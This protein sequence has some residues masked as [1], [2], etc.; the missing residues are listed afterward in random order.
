M[1]ELRQQESPMNTKLTTMSTIVTLI[2]ASKASAQQAEAP[3]HPLETPASAFE[4]VGGAYYTQGFGSLQSGVDMQHV[5]TPGLSTE[6]GVGYRINPRWA[7][8]LVG[9]YQE[10]DAQRANQARG[11]TFGVAATF[12]ATPYSRLDPWVQLGTGYR[13]L[14]E[15]SIAP[16][17]DLVTHGFELAKLTVGLDYR[18]TR[19]IAFAPVI[20]VDLT[21]PLWQTQG[22]IS[23][24]RVSTFIF[25]G[26]QVRFDLAS[27][28]IGGPQPVAQTQLTQAAICPPAPPPQAASKPVSPTL[29]VDEEVLSACKMNLDNVDT[30]PKFAFDKAEL[31]P[32]DLEVLQKVAECFA[33]GPL[34][35]DAVELVGRADPR[36]TVEYN[37]ALGLRRAESVATFFEQHGV[38]H[39]RIQRASR[40]KRDATGTDGATWARDR[41]VDMSRIEIRLSRR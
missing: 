18:A 26:T 15:S 30:A 39:A 29:S 20:G 33:T 31:L 21:L 38:E 6:V 10:F 13:F 17:P 8:S 32:A 36:G 12:H 41:R 19:D 25:A 7:L 27:K 35:N 37:D 3:E 4:I 14:W 16:T 2:F 1:H 24:P 5:I 22:A 34:K 23:D 40:G 28:F 11:A 9:A